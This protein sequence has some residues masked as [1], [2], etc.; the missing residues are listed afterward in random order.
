MNNRLLL[1]YNPKAGKGLFLQ[2]L[3]EVIDMFTKA[4]FAVETYPT[5]AP[6]DAVDKV[7]YLEGEYNVIVPAG[8]DGTLDEVVTGLIRS[9]RDVP[10]GYIPVGSTNDYASSLG[11][12]SNVIEA[13]GDIISGHPRG[14][15]VGLFNKNHVFIYVA[16]FGAFTDVAYQTNQDMKNALGHVAYIMEGAK[17]LGDLKSYMMRV[18][19]PEMQIQQDYIFGMITNSLSVGG[20]KNLTGKQV[21]LDDGEFEVTLV[22]NPKNVLEMQEIIGSIL[23]A[24]R[25]TDLIDYFKTDSIE[26][27]ALEEIPWTFD[28][29]YG[30][31]HTQAKIE[32]RRKAIQIVLDR[33]NRTSALT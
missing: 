27:T 18:V 9:G 20:F 5:Q 7:Q 29:E 13:V 21:K 12:S 33:H 31:D 1:I 32:D 4:G 28:G 14:V 3:P 17:R 19:T 22:R 25:D 16:A 11:L 15:D 26:I 8:G 2:H 23:T 30:G 6:G 10:I 24:N